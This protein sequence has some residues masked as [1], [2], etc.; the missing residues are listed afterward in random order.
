MVAHLIQPSGKPGVRILIQDLRGSRTDPVS[1]RP[2]SS[3]RELSSLPSLEIVGSL[4]RLF[5]Q[6]AL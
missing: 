3:L 5:K 4:V 6:L 2:A 1:P